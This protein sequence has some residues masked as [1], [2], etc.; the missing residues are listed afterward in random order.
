MLPVPTVLTVCPALYCQQLLYKMF[1]RF[2]LRVQL[3][4]CFLPPSP[5]RSRPPLLFHLIYWQ[6]RS[7][8]RFLEHLRSSPAFA[9]A[10]G[11]RPAPTVTCFLHQ[12]LGCC[13]S[14]LTCTIW[15]LMAVCVL[16]GAIPRMYCHR[17]GTWLL[18]SP[19]PATRQRRTQR[20]S[21]IR[22]TPFAA[23]MSTRMDHP[24]QRLHRQ[25]IPT[26]A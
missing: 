23:P 1:L 5:R 24:C 17:Q 20:E 16:E 21:R 22:P 18:R 7:L 3:G 19:A 15:R 8:P 6:K 11:R 2:D 14:A 9:I 25:P 10:A 4:R 12:L 26:L 13:E